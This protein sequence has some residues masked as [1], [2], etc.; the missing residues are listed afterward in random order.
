MTKE[1]LDYTRFASSTDAKSVYGHLLN[2]GFQASSGVRLIKTVDTR[3]E[4]CEINELVK[5]GTYTKYGQ[6]CKVL[7]NKQ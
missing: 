5:Y 2:I 7:H 4:N 3:L 6:Y 1:E